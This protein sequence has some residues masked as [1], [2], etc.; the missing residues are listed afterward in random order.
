MNSQKICLECSTKLIFIKCPRDRG[1]KYL[2]REQA[3]RPCAGH[4]GAR[5]CDLARTDPDQLPSLH[6]VT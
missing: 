4:T 1:E 5:T 3:V 6:E 2:G